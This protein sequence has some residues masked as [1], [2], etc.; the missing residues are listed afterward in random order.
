MLG[1][2]AYRM[3]LVSLDEIIDVLSRAIEQLARF[4][5]VDDA[6]LH[7]SAKIPKRKALGLFG[8]AVDNNQKHC[9]I[10]ANAHC[11]AIVAMGDEGLVV[12]HRQHPPFVNQQRTRRHNI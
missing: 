4:R 2:R 1:L 9:A 11:G 5:C 7:E 8:T 6:H 12:A 10:G 3:Q